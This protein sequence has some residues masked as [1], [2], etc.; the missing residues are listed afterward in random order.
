MS[1]YKQNLRVRFPP[2]FG[3]SS[4]WDGR[5][6]ADFLLA[7]LRDLLRGAL[8]RDDGPRGP[9]AICTTTHAGQVDRVSLAFQIAD[10]LVG[11]LM[12]AELRRNFLEPE[13]GGGR[14]ATMA[15]DELRIF[16]EEDGVREPVLSDRRDDLRDLRS[17]V[18]SGVAIISAHRAHPEGPCDPGRCAGAHPKISSVWNGGLRRRNLRA[19]HPPGGGTR[20]LPEDISPTTGPTP[21]GHSQDGSSV[22]I[23]LCRSA[24]RLKDYQCG[25]KD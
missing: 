12:D 20:H 15:G 17:R 14:E 22:C 21:G 18:Q 13:L 5:T 11:L 8:R 9:A 23:E 19:P 2:H 4:P 10:E 1:D 3:R 6:P 25:V 24:R 16:V 7:A